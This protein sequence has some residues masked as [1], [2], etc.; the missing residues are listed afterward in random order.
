MRVF[1]SVVATLPL[2]A[3]ASR[4]LPPAK[5]V[6]QYAGRERVHHAA[7]ERV[8]VDRPSWIW[9]EHIEHLTFIAR[10]AHAD[11]G[12][13]HSRKEVPRVDEAADK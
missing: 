8:A 4:E 13:F 10:C 11:G 5:F 6:R 9:N 1:I 7:R 2:V 12:C 3:C